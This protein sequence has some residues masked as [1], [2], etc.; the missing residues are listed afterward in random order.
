LEF[1]IGDADVDFLVQF[2]DD[3]FRRALGTAKAVS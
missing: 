1:R 2:F 3:F